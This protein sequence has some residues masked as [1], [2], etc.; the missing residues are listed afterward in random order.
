MELGCEVLL[1]DG[2]FPVFVGIFLTTHEFRL[3]LCGSLDR[4]RLPE[5]SASSFAPSNT[6]I[7]ATNP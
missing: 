3:E 5:T 6:S 2:G 7:L 4:Q 1:R